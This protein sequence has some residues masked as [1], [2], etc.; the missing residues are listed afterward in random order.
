[1][2]EQKKMMSRLDPDADDEWERIDVDHHR[3]TTSAGTS[4]RV[5]SSRNLRSARK[6]LRS[7]VRFR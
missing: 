1:M 6:N 4:Q 3:S 7:A 5:T 2:A